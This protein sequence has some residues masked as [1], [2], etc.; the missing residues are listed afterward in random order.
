MELSDTHLARCIEIWRQHQDR[1]FTM[2]REMGTF[3]GDAGH[4]AE[5][6]ADEMVCRYVQEATR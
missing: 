2:A 6:I 4:L 5:L 3:S 1:A